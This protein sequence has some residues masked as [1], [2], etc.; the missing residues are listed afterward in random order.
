MMDCDG[1]EVESVD[2]VISAM[3]QHWLWA[4]SMRSLRTA[5]KIRLP[6]Q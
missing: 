1:T 2:A 4:S 6:G 5:R 3:L